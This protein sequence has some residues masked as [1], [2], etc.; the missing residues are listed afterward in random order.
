VLHLI[1][2][3]DLAPEIVVGQEEPL[4]ILLSLLIR[5]RRAA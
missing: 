1:S 4:P 2:E 3:I 5:D